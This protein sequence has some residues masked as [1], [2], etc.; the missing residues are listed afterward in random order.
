ACDRGTVLVVEDDA[1]VSELATKVLTRAGY[2]VA[3]VDHASAALT[4]LAAG[5]PV[6]LVFS[7]ILLPQGMSGITLAHTVR[8]LCPMLPVLLTTGYAEA[9]SDAEAVGL[10]ILRKP[11]P[12]H[13]LLGIIGGM[14]RGRIAS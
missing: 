7:D 6:D 12:S 1:D 13:D 3:Q 2:A 8:T 11:Y 14:L 5:A 9:M 10:T 4:A